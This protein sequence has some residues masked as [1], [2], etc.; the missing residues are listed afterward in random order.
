MSKGDTQELKMAKNYCKYFTVSLVPTA[1]L[2]L[3]ILF[4]GGII[5]LPVL[6]EELTTRT[7]VSVNLFRASMVSRLSHSRAQDSY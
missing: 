6:Y 7:K 1:A 5:I 3:V 2:V 4:A